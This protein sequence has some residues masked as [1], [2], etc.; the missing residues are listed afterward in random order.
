[1]AG[2]TGTGGTGTGGANPPSRQSPTKPTR[3]QRPGRTHF[4]KSVVPVRSGGDIR[5]SLR[6]T[7]DQWGRRPCRPTLLPPSQTHRAPS[8]AGVPVGQLCLRHLKPIAPPVGPASLPAYPSPIRAR[9]ATNPRK[10]ARTNRGSP[11]LQKSKFVR[12]FSLQK[13][14]FPPVHVNSARAITAFHPSIEEP[15]FATRPPAVGYQ[16]KFSAQCPP[17]SDL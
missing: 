14:P 8:R 13:Q 12:N 6:H 2:G 5:K 7:H 15:F 11:K 10:P 16:S 17:T 4:S 9:T 3:Q 1:M